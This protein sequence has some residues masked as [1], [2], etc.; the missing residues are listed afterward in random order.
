MWIVRIR[1]DNHRDPPPVHFLEYGTCGVHFGDRLAETRGVQLHRRSHG[2]DA[3]QAGADDIH[4]LLG[5]PRRRQ[6]LGKRYDVFDEVRVGDGVEEPG[7]GGHRQMLEIGP[8]KGSYF[9]VEVALLVIPQ[10]WMYGAEHVMEFGHVVQFLQP[11][12]HAGDVVA[13]DPETNIDPAGP[14]CSRALDHG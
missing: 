9:A 2:G 11:R 13:F 14:S 12:L 5:V 1:A 4:L 7:L 8:L 3:I 10:V 6:V